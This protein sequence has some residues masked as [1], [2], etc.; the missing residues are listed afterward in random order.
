MAAELIR[1][2]HG[3]RGERKASRTEPELEIV[4]W[5]KPGWKERYR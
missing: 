4:E 5:W 3:A 1:L 2:R